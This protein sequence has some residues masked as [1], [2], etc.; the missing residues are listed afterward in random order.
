MIVGKEFT[1]AMA[2]E[3]F[4][5]QNI[6]M[7]ITTVYFFFLPNKCAT[8]HILVRPALAQGEVASNT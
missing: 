2:Y 5:F 8:P 1:S 6:Q 7:G 3:T 4:V